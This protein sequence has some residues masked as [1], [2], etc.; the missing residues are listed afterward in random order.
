MDE[1]NNIVSTIADNLTE[2]LTSEEKN[3]LVEIVD[4][5]KHPKRFSNMGAR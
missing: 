1:N 3:E 5:L 4:F 2:T